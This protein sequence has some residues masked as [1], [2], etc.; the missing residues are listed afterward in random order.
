MYD[1]LVV[2][3][4]ILLL[5]SLVRVNDMRAALHGAGHARAMRLFIIGHTGGTKGWWLTSDGSVV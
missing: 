2:L 5:S 4:Q 1:A 3:R